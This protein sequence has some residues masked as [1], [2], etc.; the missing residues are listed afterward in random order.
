MKKELMSLI[1]GFI[2]ILIPVFANAEQAPKKVV[3]LANSTLVDI[4]KDPVIVK[5]VKEENAK[6]KS[7]EQIKAKDEEWKN[8]PGIADYMKA[9]MASEC[10]QHLRGIQDSKSFYA[11]IFV[12][13]N[14][15]ANVAMTDKTSDFW[16]G[17]EAKFQKSFNNGKGAVFVDEVEFDDSTQAYLV[18]VSVPVI[19][20]DK[21]IGAITFGIDVDQIQ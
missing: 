12:M 7:L 11:E 1:I 17:D 8:T 14:Q 18:Q 6:A 19:D 2:F 21:V 10:G 9:I 4:G 15:G 13:D 5:A 20:G 16:Q 3:D